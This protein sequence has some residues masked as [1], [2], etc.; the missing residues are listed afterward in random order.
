MSAS[1]IELRRC[2]HVDD[3]DVYFNPVNHRII[4]E[5][6]SDLATG[7]FEYPSLRVVRNWGINEQDFSRLQQ[8]LRAQVSVASCQDNAE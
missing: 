6:K 8:Q 3:F 4:C 2:G 1:T 7:L 5:R